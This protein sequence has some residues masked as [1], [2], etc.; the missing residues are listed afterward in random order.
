MAPPIDNP[1]DRIAH[2][3]DDDSSDYLKHKYVGSRNSYMALR[4]FKASDILARYVV[5]SFNEHFRFL[6]C[7]CGPGILLDVLARYPIGYWGL[8]ISHEMLKLAD[9]RPETGRSVL[10]EK[11][12]VRGDVENLPF[13]SGSFD[14][15]ACL[16]VIEYLK[17]DAHLLSEM[18][19]VVKPKGH[20]LIAVTNQRSYNLALE[21]PLNWM[22]RHR[23]PARIL[24]L[25]KVALGHGEFRQAEF[26]KRRHLPRA[27]DHTLAARGLKVV[28][29]ASWGFNFLPHPLQH[30]CPHSWNDFANSAYERSI[31][32]MIKHFGEGYMV[33][34]QRG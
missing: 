33:L 31:N 16:G 11:H 3:F 10:T 12:L 29:S 17:D 7:G 9:A 2:F 28:A 19:R 5:P 30:L 27:F 14:A 25:A 1:K 34:C 26:E 15:A 24:N 32:R 18:Q 4:R 20:L 23:V 22:R 6:D 13:A 8:D 21:G